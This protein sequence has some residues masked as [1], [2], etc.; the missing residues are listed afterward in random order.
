[1]KGVVYPQSW[2]HLDRFKYSKLL[3]VI[4]DTCLILRFPLAV[5]FENTFPVKA[6]ISNLL[7]TVVYLWRHCIVVIS[8]NV[9]VV[10]VIEGLHR[11]ISSSSMQCLACSLGCKTSL[12]LVSCGVSSWYTTI[13]QSSFSGLALVC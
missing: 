1:M 8:A 5:A 10:V 9:F 12:E 7:K 3:S 2:E 11:C 6:K 13:G 4:L